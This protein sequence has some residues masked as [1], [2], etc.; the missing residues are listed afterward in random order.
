[1]RR[2]ADGRLKASGPSGLG[3]S[4]LRRAGVVLT[5][6]ASLVVG[7]CGGGGDRGKQPVAR[8][9][10]ALTLAVIGD[11]PYG[12]EQVAAFPD[13]VAD[14]NRD[15]KVDVV[16]HL[17]DIKTG[18]STCTDK[19][20][21]RLRAL[22]NTFE[23]PFVYTPGDNEWTDCHRRAAGGYV[24]TKRLERLRRIF[25]A[26]PG[27]A[28][29]GRPM[30][31][32]TQAKQPGF[33][34][35]VENQLWVR[36]EVVFSTVH[37]VGS[38]NGLAPWSDV[39]ETAKQRRLRLAEFDRRQAAGL[40][41]LD[42][43]FALAEEREARGVV[44]AMQ[45][46]MFAGAAGGGY[47]AIVQRLAERAS[48]FDGPVLLLEG[49]TH[50]FLV[51]EPLASGSSVHAVTTRAPNVTLI[52]VEGETAGEWLRLSVDPR[53]ERLFSWTRERV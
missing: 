26:Q 34:E 2:R 24:P 35:F 51:D 16:L 13:L 31:M 42:R 14:V 6:L 29:G 27:R 36:S 32:R 43:T 19:R 53:A 37:V 12:P 44:V 3:A 7:G 21:K 11:T 10:P 33:E 50:K 41:W 22:F 48:R 8:S 4:S 5:L 9:A 47:D 49:D 25:Y 38:S 52:V 23:D 40:A 45:A 30:R 17:G 20:F 39:A 46:D 1:M 28:L 15:P 18:A